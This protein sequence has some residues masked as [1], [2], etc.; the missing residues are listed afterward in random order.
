MTKNRNLIL[1][2]IIVLASTVLEYFVFNARIPNAEV[3]NTN[4]KTVSQPTPAEIATAGATPS[5]DDKGT[6]VIF[7]SAQS[8]QDFLQK[9][10]LT[11]TDIT[12]KSTR[13]FIVH[14]PIDQITPSDGV[15]TYPNRNYKAL[16]TPNDTRYAQQWYLPKIS[17]P[18]A[19]DTSTGN[20]VTTTIAVIDTGFALNHEDLTSQ[21]APNGYDF[22]CN[23]TSPKAG[24]ADCDAY[25]TNNNAA[26][27]T[28][29]AGVAGAATNNSIGVSSLDWN[30]KILPL[31]VL[32]DAGSG[33]TADVATAIDYAVTNGVEVISMSLGGTSVDTFLRQRIDAA[34]AAGVVV[35]A[36]AGNCGDPNTYIANG[37]N[38]VGQIVEP[39]N[40]PPVISVGATDSNDTRAGFSSYGDNLDVIAPG[41]SIHSTSWSNSNQTTGYGNASGTSLAT[42]IVAGQAALIK[43]TQP[44]STPA[45]IEN[46]IKVGID[47]VGGLN[48]Q[49]FSTTY[50]YGRINAKKSLDYN[51]YS[52]A[53]QAAFTNE[54][55]STA[56]DLN[57]LS[58]G[59][60]AWLQVSVT[61]TGT[62][63]WQKAGAN[64]VRL[65]TWGG[66]DRHS[67]YYTPGSW[68]SA[69]RPASLS[70]NSVAP[71]ESGTFEFP[72][73]VPAGGGSFNEQFNLVKEGVAWLPATSLAFS[74]SVYG[75][76]TWE[77]AG[78]A[79]YTNESKSTPVSLANTSPGQVVYFVVS[80]RNTGNAT[81]FK[82]G[83]YPMR[84]ATAKPFDR[85]SLFHDPRWLSANRPAGLKED[86]VAPSAVGT[87]EAYYQIP[88]NSG[89]TPEYLN[90]VVEGITHL[91][92]V[93][94]YL[95]ATI[96]NSYAWE[97]AGQ[98][99]YTNQSKST[100]IDLSALTPGQVFYFV[101]SA[102]NAGTATWFKTGKYPTLLGTARPLD[103]TS[104]FYEAR[105]LSPNRST[106]I[107]EDT[108]TPNNIATFEGYYK[109]PLLGGAYKEYLLPVV[110]GITWLNDLGLYIP[111]NVN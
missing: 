41:V 73:T 75:T 110:D 100:P 106:S 40:Y 37:C 68:L 83:N 19:W 54:S 39:A 20:G 82:Q 47:K 111:A 79:A 72:I 27:G 25:P 64:P 93:G 28:F 107:S 92:Q 103:R 48:G 35:I 63:T 70:E 85:T 33:S 50:G 102:R 30:V 36:A 10:K 104:T 24:D 1:I 56:L 77:F 95:P 26:H 99:A 18:D 12:N 91:N 7:N 57:H 89:L 86:S 80:A 97:F 3:K 11:E 58:A 55:K 13:T 84:L 109:A 9:N 74:T 108:V 90:P 88:N 23:D 17:A 16:L 59:Q 66:Q 45:V 94:L 31:Q 65:G 15:V 29:T 6:I 69:N 21:W 105:W 43:S 4:A 52:T 8:R 22:V 78:Q 61:N 53:T 46:I 42:P 62:S 98:A 14:K 34:I 67:R 5:K 2:I 51:A 44:T 96:N 87:F 76:Y 81:W 49:N 32:S 38:S 71:G 101:V 60:T